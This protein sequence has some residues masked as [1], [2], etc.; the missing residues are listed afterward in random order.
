MTR[1]FVLVPFM[2]LLIMALFCRVTDKVSVSTLKYYGVFFLNGTRH[3]MERIAM[4]EIRVM[5]IYALYGR[6]SNVRCNYRLSGSLFIYH[7]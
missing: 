7:C 5:Y 3:N 1:P 6:K 2:P 4:R